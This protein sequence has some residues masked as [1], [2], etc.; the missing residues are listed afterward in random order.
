LLEAA[1]EA[2]GEQESVERC[3]VLS[4]LGRA[5]FEIGFNERGSVLLREATDMARRLGDRRTLCETLISE[6]IV[7]TG[8]PW[9]ASE[10]PDRRRALDELLAVAEEIGDPY[11]LSRAHF[12][13]FGAFLEMGDLSG[14]EASLTHCREIAENQPGDLWGIS[15]ARDAGNPARRVRRCRAFRARGA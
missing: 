5:L 15:S 7:T 1:L 10:F 9:S 6:H 11:L 4:R 13:R 8:Y 14:F 12:R 2:L 3:Q